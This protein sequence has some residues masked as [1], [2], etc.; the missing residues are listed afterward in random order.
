MERDE[1]IVC[2][3]DFCPGLRPG[4]HVALH[5]E[6]CLL[7]MEWVEHSADGF[8]NRGSAV[9]NGQATIVAGVVAVALITLLKPRSHCAAPTQLKCTC[10]F[11]SQTMRN[12][13]NESNTSYLRSLGFERP[14]SS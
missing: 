11:V 5:G 10:N 13:W 1:R 8:L 2:R 7:M 14:T 12:F 6:S 9:T 4:L 3:R